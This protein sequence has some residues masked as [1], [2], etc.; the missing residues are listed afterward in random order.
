MANGNLLQILAFHGVNIVIKAIFG[1]AK[2]GTIWQIRKRTGK[3]TG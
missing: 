2:M 3:V 1:H